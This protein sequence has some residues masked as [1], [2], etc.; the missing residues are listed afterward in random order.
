MGAEAY[1][2]NPA[3][4]RV[5]SEVA[6]HVVAT[7]LTNTEKVTLE[8]IARGRGVS[9]GV[10]LRLW[11]Q[12]AEGGV[13]REAAP[14]PTSVP[15]PETFEP[16]TFDA[17]VDE[18]VAAGNVDALRTMGETL[19]DA[20]ESLK[21]FVDRLVVAGDGG[22]LR[23]V[24]SVVSHALEVH[25][26]C[27]ATLEAMDAVA[28]RQQKRKRDKEPA[29]KIGPQPAAEQLELTTPPAN[30]KAD[31]VALLAT[32]P[33]VPASMCREEAPWDGV[34]PT[35]LEVLRLLA[36][37][38]LTWD[39]ECKRWPRVRGVWITE[40]NGQLLKAGLVRTERGTRLWHATERGIAAAQLPAVER[41][42]RLPGVPAGPDARTELASIAAFLR[43]R[44]ADRID[45]AG[46]A[47]TIGELVEQRAIDRT[48]A[49]VR[50]A[51]GELEGW[52]VGTLRS[53]AREAAAAF[54]RALGAKC[55]S[56]TRRVTDV[57]ATRIEHREY[58][59]G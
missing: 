18:L 53:S 48:A 52:D 44:A 45:N 54:V 25:L 37:K 26:A 19:G 41:T 11:V 56:R 31:L 49:A 38:P 14:A 9:P 16:P 40:L 51:A 17:V 59:S 50:R 57:L 27:N 39:A 55:D 30:V 36:K 34:P 3:A 2:P 8:G 13:L 20:V 12:L 22:A 29:A 15:S 10:M 24:S 35:P 58:A 21:T 32:L 43:I 47:G 23:E 6:S 46:L 4:R 1:K 33:G 42:R 5:A 28:T 7:R